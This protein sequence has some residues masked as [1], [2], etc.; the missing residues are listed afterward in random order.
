MG[1]LEKFMSHLTSLQE[2]LGSIWSP[3]NF[4]SPEPSEFLTSIYFENSESISNFKGSGKANFYFSSISR[5]P[6]I[7]VSTVS[8]IARNPKFYAYLTRDSVIYLFLVIYNW[9]QFKPTLWASSYYISYILVVE[10]VDIV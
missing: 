4:I 1:S 5:L 9:N 3:N 2:I 10:R 7:G 6:N 8:T